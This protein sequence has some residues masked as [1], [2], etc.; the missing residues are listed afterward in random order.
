M[1]GPQVHGQSGSFLQRAEF[2]SQSR[3]EK[4]FS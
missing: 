3:F 1:K 4:G 2:I